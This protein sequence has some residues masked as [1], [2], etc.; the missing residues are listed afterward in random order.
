MALP[1]SQRPALL[2]PEEEEELAGRQLDS[3]E[4]SLQLWLGNTLEQEEGEAGQGEPDP[5]TGATYTE[6]PVLAYRMLDDALQV[7]ARV[8]DLHTQRTLQAKLTVNIFCKII[9]SL[10]HD[11]PKTFQVGLHQLASFASRYKELVRAC[12]LMERKVAAA[13]NCQKFQSLAQEAKTRWWKPGNHVDTDEASANYFE[14]LINNFEEVKD[15]TINSLV[16]QSFENTEKQFLAL[17]TDDWNNSFGAVEDILTHLNGNFEIFDTLTVSNY[18]ILFSA[19]QDRVGI[20]YISAMLRRKITFPQTTERK[21]A[22]EKIKKETSHCR[23]FFGAVSAGKIKVRDSPFSLIDL[24]ADIISGD[25]EMLMLDLMTFISK[26][27]DVSEDQIICLLLLRGVAKTEARQVA[28]DVV[29]E[30][31][32]TNTL[33]TKSLMSSV[34]VNLSFFNL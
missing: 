8:S 18:D 33:K 4:A 5:A 28:A 19:I 15:E 23:E 10:F 14:E 20:L 7:A 30:F 16:H 1:V 2:N 32:K 22:A 21:K 6:L 3:V 11:K 12:Q 13:N 24:L 25:E 31:S 26:Y 29:S 9:S 17:F 27:G 34:E